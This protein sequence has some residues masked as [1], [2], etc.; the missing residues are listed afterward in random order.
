[1][2]GTAP[3][4]K[5]KTYSTLGTYVATVTVTDDLGQTAT[6]SKDFTITGSGVTASF[7]S[8]P[9]DPTTADTVQFN[10]IA[11]TASA[12][13][14]ITEWH[15]DFGD[16]TVSRTD[17]TNATTEHQFTAARTYVVRLTVID[18]AQRSGTVTAEVTV[19]V[20]AP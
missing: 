10:G 20:T 1:M 18:S 13:A 4:A 8:S 11:S 16:G 6:A 9:T 5:P 3:P 14:E 12:G 7:T 17:K 2:L 15:W 19:T